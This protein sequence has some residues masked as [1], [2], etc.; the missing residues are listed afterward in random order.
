MKISDITKDTFKT[1]VLDT[2]GI[3]F[4]DFFATWCGPCKLT[5]PIIE[6]LAEEYKDIKFVQVDVDQNGELATEYSIF[7]IP[8]FI[9][10]K[11][12]EVVSQFSGGR[13][14]EG[15]LEEINKIIHG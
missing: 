7:S 6:Q 11:N 9:I 14:K 10:F 15:F 5:A 2:K 8:T 4:V 12:G 1:E 3:V 13:G